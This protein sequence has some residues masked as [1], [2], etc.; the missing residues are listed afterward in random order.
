VFLVQVEFERLQDFV[1]PKTN[2]ADTVPANK[3]KKSACS[4]KKI[5][6]QKRSAAD[7]DAARARIL[8]GAPPRLTH[9]HAC[10]SFG[11]FRTYDHKKE[12]AKQPSKGGG[13]DQNY[14]NVLMPN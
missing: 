6:L 5:S 14:F 1:R 4:E 13:F 2:G 3:Q 11:T 7:N 10:S 9:M 8:G 12:C